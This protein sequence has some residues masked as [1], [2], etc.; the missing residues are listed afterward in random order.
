MDVWFFLHVGGAMVLVGSLV[1]SATALVGAWRA[2][3][4]G[5]IRLG[6]RALLLGALPAY[7]VMRIAAQLLV[8]DYDDEAAW[9]GIGFGVS[10]LSLLLIIASTVLAGIS[11]KRAAGGGRVRAATI[12]IGLI[13][14]LYLVAIWAMTTKPL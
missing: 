14:V 5:N 4:A 3:D 11:A 9:V 1:L 10:E 13:L 2:D 12:I 6:Y 8:E 7:F